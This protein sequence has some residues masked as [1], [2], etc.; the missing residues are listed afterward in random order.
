M[1]YQ[2]K[3]T[4]LDGG[5]GTMLQQK[6]LQ[7]GENPV[8]LSLTAADKIME[9][10]QEY[11]EAGADIVLTNTFGASAKKLADTGASVT[12][13]ITTAVTL[14]KNA[15]GERAKV[16]LDIG[17]LGELLAPSGTLHFDEAYDLFKEQVI[18]GKDAGADLIFIETMTDLGEVRAA[19][20]A[21]KENSDLPVFVSMSFEP[22]GRTFTGVLPES[23]A[24][25][26]TGLGVNALGL[27]CSMGPVE[28]ADIVAKLAAHTHLPIVV[29]P[30]AGLPD[31][32][33]GIFPMQAE[34]FA[35]AIAELTNHGAIILGGCCGTTPAHI[36]AI[37]AKTATRNLPQTRKPLTESIICSATKVRKIDAPLV[38]GERI[39]PTGKKAFRESLI[40]GDMQYLKREAVKQE[41]EGAHILD[42]NVGVPE[43]DEATT[44]QEAV[45]AIESVSGL[46]LQIDSSDPKALEAGLRH[47]HGKALLNSVNG[48]QAILDTLLPIAKKYGAAVLGLT[49][50]ENG[51]PPSAAGR[52]KIAERILSETTKHGIPKEDVFI[53]CL[54]LT[55]SA[56][57]A[58]AV[59]TL[60]AIRLVKAQ[61]GLKTALG[62]SNIS[63]GLPNRSKINETF[64]LMAL[65]A[66]LDLAIINPADTQMMH[67]LAAWNLLRGQDHE[68]RNWIA[69]SANGNAP[70]A[71]AP[72]GDTDI[73][74]AVMAGLG[75]EAAKQAKS[76]LQTHAPMEIVTQKL[77]PALD[78]VGT[79]FEQGTLFLPQLLSAA[80]AAGHAFDVVKKALAKEGT[81]SV[82]KG[83]I[84]LA[85]VKGDIH[86]IGKNIVAVIL[87]N[88]GYQVIDLGR[89]VSPQT[90]VDK[91]IQENVTLV[92]LS[93]LMTTTLPYMQETIALLKATKPD[94]KTVV[95][96]AVL[97]ADFAAELSADF[98][99]KDAKDAVN[100]ARE[101]FGA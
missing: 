38:I 30:N 89:D 93:A 50:D 37:K 42:V 2:D 61:L 28:M 14:A 57:P 71:P 41:S 12:E 84:I 39:N 76:L 22:N 29:K 99:A 13:V 47:Y 95:G 78:L 85:T 62:V 5:M 7:A 43:I 34:E 98:Y 40:A 16:A 21:A 83:K 87:E 56:E 86:D 53:D 88:Y 90:I 73:T 36:Q 32:K 48:E 67:T 44:M 33:T 52:L 96:G 68:S 75:E 97:T 77:I 17:P 9:I 91:A 81:T 27:N 66:G 65:E 20:L 23:F 55:V 4:I 74:T 6:G 31:P 8:L 59:E 58:G 69:L 26:A 100:I 25:V 80:T 60:N 11:V 63:F 18:A 1:A 64:F 35:D 3:F 45:L 94:C 10:H 101:V 79:E 70:S 51:I 19:I 92:G 24:L 46:P 82:T 54:C 49:L 72:T 15:V